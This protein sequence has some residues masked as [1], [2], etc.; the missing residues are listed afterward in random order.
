MSDG[1][2]ANGCA[3][4]KRNKYGEREHVNSSANAMKREKRVNVRGEYSAFY[5]DNLWKSQKQ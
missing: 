1:S 3:Q 2:R 5:G 4:R